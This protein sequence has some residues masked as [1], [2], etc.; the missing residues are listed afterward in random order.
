MLEIIYQI[1]PANPEFPQKLIFNVLKKLTKRCLK[2]S[3]LH[4]NIDKMNE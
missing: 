4:Y 2:R 3:H 1:F